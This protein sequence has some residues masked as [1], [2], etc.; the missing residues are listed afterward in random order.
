MKMKKLRIIETMIPKGFK[1]DDNKLKVFRAQGTK[2]EKRS[3]AMSPI[4]MKIRV[5]C[6]ESTADKPD[7]TKSNKTEFDI[8]GGLYFGISIIIRFS[9]SKFFELI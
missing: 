5:A 1:G 3:R 9:L 4:S 6:C 2:G 8:A 7:L